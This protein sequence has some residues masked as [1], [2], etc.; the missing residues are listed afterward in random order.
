MTKAETTKLEKVSDMAIRMEERQQNMEEKLDSIEKKLDKFIEAS[1][2][3]F[4]TR[5]E[6]AAIAAFVGIV[7]SVVMVILNVKEKL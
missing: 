4:I 5:L 3:K 7:V 6:T 1:E 2:H